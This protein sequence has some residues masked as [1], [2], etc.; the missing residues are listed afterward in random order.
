M[1]FLNHPSMCIVMLHAGKA[2][3]ANGDRYV[4]QWQHGKRHGQGKWLSSSS[5]LTAL[6]AAAA[7]AGGAAAEARESYVGQWV[8]DQR[9]GQGV[10]VFA[11][12]GR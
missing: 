4:G 9:E 10:A 3:Y 6:A 7:A 8:D 2:K 1:C 11:D 5:G 12:G